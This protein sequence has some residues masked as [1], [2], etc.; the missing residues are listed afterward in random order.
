MIKR[1]I[2]P[3][4]EPYAVE[5]CDRCGSDGT[6]YPYDGELLCEE[7]LQEEL[8]ELEEYQKCECCGD[9]APVYDVDGRVLCWD[10]VKLHYDDD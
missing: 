6:L 9:Y 2:E 4:G 3:H 7:C 10:C 8:T 5:L 1:W